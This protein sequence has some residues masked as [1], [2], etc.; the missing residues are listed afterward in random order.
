MVIFGCHAKGTR[1]EYSRVDL[2]S[3]N[4]LDDLWHVQCSRLLR[5]FVNEVPL[6][7]DLYPVNLE[8]ESNVGLSGFQLGGHHL[9][10]RLR[11]ANLQEWRKWH[12]RWRANDECRKQTDA[13]DPGPSASSSPMASFVNFCNNS[14][15]IF[16]T[17]QPLDLND[18]GIC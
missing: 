6:R 8:A 17:N 3:E 9:Y 2:R 1:V 11:S 10:V 5:V 18:R 7:L 15:R 16:D 13:L 12:A 4:E 14:D